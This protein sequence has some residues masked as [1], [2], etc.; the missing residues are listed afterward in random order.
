MVATIRIVH[1]VKSIWANDYNSAQGLWADVELIQPLFYFVR[2][3]EIHQTGSQDMKESHRLLHQAEA[4]LKTTRWK[5]R[6]KRL[7]F[8][9][10]AVEYDLAEYVKLRLDASPQMALRHKERPLLDYA[11][12]PQ[13]TRFFSA[14]TRSL[15]IV[16]LLLEKRANPNEKYADWTVWQRFLLASRNEPSSSHVKFFDRPDMYEILLQLVKHGADLEAVTQR[17]SI[18]ST[19]TGRAGDLSKPRSTY[20]VDARADD[21]LRSDLSQERYSMI[22]EARP[23]EK[24][25]CCLM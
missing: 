13:Q 18:Q 5:W 10:H 12:R 2:E 25:H 4:L 24:N 19:L 17:T 15:T 22:L 21:W 14:T 3:I 1:R 6:N 16:A 23:T 11:L 20:R 8:V 7:A 9:G